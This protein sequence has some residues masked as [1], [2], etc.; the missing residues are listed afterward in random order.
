MELLK[1]RVEGEE[2]RKPRCCRWHMYAHLGNSSRLLRSAAPVRAAA[3][4][5]R[6]LRCT[7]INATSRT[8]HPSRCG[9]EGAPSPYLG[10]AIKG[11][12]HESCCLVC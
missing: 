1:S 5:T 10:K 6:R 11:V 7:R 8:G 12:T 3:K 2:V 4:C 9:E